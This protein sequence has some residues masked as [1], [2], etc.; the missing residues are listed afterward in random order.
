[1]SLLSS[2]L[3]HTLLFWHS[4]YPV[5]VEAGLVF[6]KVALLM[7]LAGLL[8]MLLRRRSAMARA[9]VWRLALAAL[10]LLALWQV[11]PAPLK[12]AGFHVMVVDDSMR[13]VTPPAPVVVPLVPF[14]PVSWWEPVLKDIE[15]WLPL[16]WWLGFAVF[17]GW[18]VLRG[19]TGLAWL[20]KHGLDAPE[21]VVNQCPAGLRCRLSTRI[22]TPLITGV[23]RPVVWLP[24]AAAEWPEGKLRAAFQHE[25]AHHV[26]RDAPWQW[27]GT[28][29]ACA[30]WWQPLGW[31]ALRRLKAEAEL[32]ADDWTV[33]KAIKVCDY[34]EALVDIAKDAG[35]GGMPCVGIAMARTSDLEQR[36]SA[37]IRPNRWR[38]KLGFAAGLALVVLGMGLTGIVLVSCKKKPQTYVSLAKLVAGGQMV[39]MGGA[40]TG[41]KEYLQDFYGTIIETL[42][43]SEMRKHALERVRLLSPKLKEADVEIRVTQTKGSA[44]FNVA[45]I[46][47]DREYAKVFLNALL[48]EFMAFHEAI[49]GQQTNKVVTAL[50]GD[51]A[52]SQKE[53]Q[54]DADNLQAFEK[55]NNIV[56]LAGKQNQTAELIRQLG[57]ESERQRVL[58]NELTLMLEDPEA[59]VQR[60]EQLA[61]SGGPDRVLLSQT[62]QDYLKA[63]SSLIPLKAERK[64]KTKEV[65]D[66]HPQALALD[67]KI[68]GVETVLAAYLED[69]RQQWQRQ[70]K[71]VE[72]GL[73][74]LNLRM[75]KLTEEATSVGVKLAEH[76]RLAQ[77]NRNSE[78]V[79]KQVQE[80][81]KKF[82]VSEKMT[83]DYVTVMERATNAVE[84]V[85]GW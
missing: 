49:R 70:Q 81:I 36:V 79:H 66:K 9:L 3:S 64:E 85:Q 84:D 18:K 67:V 10:V 8:V 6:A 13:S 1:M 23:W 30:W 33:M 51:R 19:A 58:A 21:T 43:S 61:T 68:A 77:K 20:R 28:L 34:A 65:G 39:S 5:L 4:L 32:A 48:D 41:Y 71:A 2:P 69:F 15:G 29:A 25:L 80:L 73:G 83:G 17:A 78:A 74:E 45:C 14:A 27:L 38:N 75:A 50:G 31:L 35:A 46:A 52:V 11:R 60:R 7:A 37:L 56:V 55:S 16:V 42:E 53:A 22:A 24:K 76:E 63:R 82:E 47:T 40:P 12:E 59:G 72:R 62:E 54:Q 26:R 44:I 57:V